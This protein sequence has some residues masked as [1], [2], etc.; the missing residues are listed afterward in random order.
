MLVD[1]FGFAFAIAGLAIARI[2][3]QAVRRLWT[4]INPMDQLHGLAGLTL[5]YR[6]QEVR[7]DQC[8][9]REIHREPSPSGHLYTRYTF[10]AI[11][12]ESIMS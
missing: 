5:N 10:D 7:L 4:P 9:L 6:G 8:V 1:L 2:A 12:R 3:Y 11:S